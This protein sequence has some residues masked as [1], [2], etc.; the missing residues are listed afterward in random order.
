MKTKTK[1]A[2]GRFILSN[3]DITSEEVWK[4]LK[5]MF[6]D[7][8]RATNWYPAMVTIK[9]IPNG[10]D[11]KPYE[12]EFIEAAGQRFPVFIKAWEEEDQFLSYWKGPSKN[13][14][15][16]NVEKYLGAMYGF[17]VLDGFNSVIVEVSYKCTYKKP[18]PPFVGRFLPKRK[19]LKSPVFAVKQMM[20]GIPFKGKIDFARAFL[21]R[22]VNEI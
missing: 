20:K 3:Q 18:F 10:Q 5:S 17:Q 21:P 11:D 2:R 19:S 8:Q 14:P 12:F 16:R 22:E 6:L 15:N 4:S 13:S 7:Y 9:P 1:A